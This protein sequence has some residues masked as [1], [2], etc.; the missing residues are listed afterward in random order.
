MH[1]GYIV[2]GVRDMARSV[3]FYRDVVGL[4]LRFETPGWT[5]FAT[6]EAT[7]ALHSSPAGPAG[8]LGVDATPGA[9]GRE[10]AAG[11]CR[12]GFSVDDLDAFHARMEA[13]DVPCTRLPVE[14]FGARLAQYLDPDGLEFG[15]GEHPRG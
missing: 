11:I 1:L 14:I 2:I 6:G 3:A 9:E 7:L 12:P 8:D 15:V 10:L 5:E 13:A 4:E